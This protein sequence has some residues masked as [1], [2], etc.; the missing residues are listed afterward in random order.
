[1]CWNASDIRPW[2]SHEDHQFEPDF[3]ELDNSSRAVHVLQIVDRKK[4]G[5][6]P[7]NPQ[8]WLDIPAQ[9]LVVLSNGTV[10]WR[11]QRLLKNLQEKKLVR[12]FERQ[13][14]RSAALPCNPVKDYP[15]S[16]WSEEYVSDDEV[17]LELETQLDAFLED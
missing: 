16:S 11:S 8:T 12:Q 10:E 15:P 2:F 3:P 17:D 13:F 14:R 9:Y 4:F 7:R 1:M 5:R 6:T